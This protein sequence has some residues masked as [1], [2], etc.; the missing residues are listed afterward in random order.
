MQYSVFN[1]IAAKNLKTPEHSA[2]WDKS[3][4]LLR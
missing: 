1:Q 4:Y 2:V 3:G